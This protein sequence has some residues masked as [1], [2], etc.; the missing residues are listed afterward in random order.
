MA[1]KIELNYSTTM[2]MLKASRP[3]PGRMK[4]AEF[5]RA[6]VDRVQRQY[7]R[8]SEA[9]VNR[10]FTS[11]LVIVMRKLIKLSFHLN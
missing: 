4:R 8:F 5:R 1:L 6:L 3:R 7:G 10:L 11:K 2:I 9:V